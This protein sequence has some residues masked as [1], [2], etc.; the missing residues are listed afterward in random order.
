MAQELLAEVANGKDPSKERDTT[1]HALAVAE[2]CDRYRE[3]A[4]AGARLSFMSAR[5]T[6]S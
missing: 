4:Q 3:A 1:R 5:P 6:T 2:L